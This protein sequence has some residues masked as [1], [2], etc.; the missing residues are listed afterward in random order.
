MSKLKLRET[1]AAAGFLAPAYVIY[2]LFL[3][4]PLFAALAMSFMDVDRFALTL[5]F[6]GFENFDWILSDKRFWATFNN[7]LLFVFLAVVGKIVL[8][9]GL[10]VLLDRSMP[11]FLLYFLRLAYFLPVLISIVFVSFIW[12][13]LFSFDL[14]VINYYLRNMGFAPSTMAD[15]RQRRFDIGRYCGRLEEPRVLPHHP[16]GGIAGRSPQSA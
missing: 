6:V 1:R 14:G 3:A 15:Q 11:T 16:F 5:N 2:L 4:I 10:A 12:K 13:F 8:G 7:T 9:L